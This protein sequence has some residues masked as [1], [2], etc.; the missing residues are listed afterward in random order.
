MGGK[1]G[2]WWIDRCIKRWVSKWM[3]GWMDGWIEIWAGKG[4]E[5]RGDGWMDRWIG[6]LL[7]GWMGGW[8]N[9]WMMDGP[10]GRWV[11]GWLDVW[12]ERSKCQKVESMGKK[13]CLVTPFPFYYM[14]CPNMPPDVSL[15][16]GNHVRVH[17]GA[18]FSP[19]LKPSDSKQTLAHFDNNQTSQS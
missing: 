16:S 8:M 7:S 9:E 18:T 10:V 17:I 11:G 6:R 15:T 19:Y 13:N 5:G 1:T 14:W 2:R 12:M 3:D 4:R